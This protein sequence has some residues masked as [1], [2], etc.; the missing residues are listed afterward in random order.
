MGAARLAAR[1][2]G[3]LTAP[4]GRGLPPP[5]PVGGGRVYGG[6]PNIGIGVGVVIPLDG[7][8]YTHD[9]TVGYD[10]PVFAGDD[11]YVAM[12]LVSAYDGRILWHTRQHLDV[13]AEHPQDLGAGVQ[14]ILGQLPARAATPVPTSTAAPASAGPNPGR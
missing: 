9:G 5:V 11:L 6:G 14:S 12:T 1:P 13:D 10:D 7:P 4:R 2:T 3:A 8:Q